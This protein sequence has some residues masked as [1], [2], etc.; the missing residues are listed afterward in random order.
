MKNKFLLL[1]VVGIVFFASCSDDDDKDSPKDF[2]GIYSTTSTDRVLDLKYSDAAFIG[3]SVDFNSADGKSATLKL[4]GVVPGECETVFS[5][6]PLESGSSVYTFSAENKNDS[7]TV[8]L[9]GSIVKGKLTVNVKF[10]QNELMKTWD[11]SSVKMAWTPHDYPLTEVDLGFTKMKIT[12]GLLATMAPTMLAKELKNY[13]QNVTFREDGNIVAAYNTATATEENPEPEADWQMSPL[14]LAQYCVKDGVC[15][16]FLSLDM[17]MRQVDMDQEGR[18]TDTDPILGAIEQLLT[19]GIPVQ[20]EKTEGDGKGALYVYL[21]QVLLKQLGPLL[22]MVESLIPE[23]MA[24]E[25][26]F[27]GKT[28]SVPIGPILENLPGALEVTTAMQVGLQ[29]KGAE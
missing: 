22:P 26:S 25:A 29:F 21:D 14:N 3:K 13:L 28:I 27:L 17:I 15:Y 20:F 11:F 7:R 19:N 2:S 16:V 6:V 8:T 10:A 5:S 12:T 18:S 1:M 9:E 24:F 4:Q 23:D